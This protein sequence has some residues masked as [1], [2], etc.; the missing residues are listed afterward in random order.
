MLV[1][2][3][4]QAE[5]VDGPGEV[6]GFGFLVVGDG[7]LQVDGLYLDAVGVAAEITVLE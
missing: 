3:V 4:E 5:V 2:V 7:F 6:G 1:V